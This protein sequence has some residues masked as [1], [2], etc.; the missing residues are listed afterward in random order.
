MSGGI[1]AVV[2]AIDFV[3]YFNEMMYVPGVATVNEAPEAFAPVVDPTIWL[4]QSAVHNHA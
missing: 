3:E 1:G 4:A 2:P